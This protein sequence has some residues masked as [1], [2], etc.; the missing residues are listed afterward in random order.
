M[1]KLKDIGDFE[2]MPQI[3]IDIINGNLSALDK[4]LSQ[5]WNIDEEIALDEYIRLSPLD[6]ALI[7][8]C[9][10]SV[11]WLVEHG[12]ELN[13]KGNP[14]FLTAVRY[15]EETIIRYIVSHG[16]KVNE[17]NKVG[18]E[19]FE[20]ALYGKRHENLS[21]VH[22]L[23][24]TVDKYGGNAFRKAVA[25]RNYDVLDFFLNNGVDINYNKPDMVYPF[26]PTPLCVAARYVDFFSLY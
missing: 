12:V 17:S 6:Y 8:E 22:A 21:V 26:K 24:H 13:V 20:Q 9:F 11:E 7:M 3:V 19:A 25:D 10:K 2:A 5:G 16:A 4:Y 18:A 23:G 1:I 15:C 14:A